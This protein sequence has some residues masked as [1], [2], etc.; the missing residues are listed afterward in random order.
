M[1]NN[2]TLIKLPSSMSDVY[3]VV[4]YIQ[5]IVSGLYHILWHVLYIT[6]IL[7]Q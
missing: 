7:F 6:S 2:V 1:E 4:L 3:N 5:W